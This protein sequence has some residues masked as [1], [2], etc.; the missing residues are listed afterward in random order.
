MLPRTLLIRVQ[1][2]DAG[3]RPFIFSVVPAGQNLVGTVTLYED[4]WQT[5]IIV[6]HPEVSGSLVEIEQIVTAPTVINTSSSAAGSFLFVKAGIVDSSGRFLRVVVRAG[7]V[8]SAYFS[9]AAG[10]SQLWP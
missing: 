3:L 6:R 4:T 5:H 9:S 1:P 8:R 10:G 2:S 7:S